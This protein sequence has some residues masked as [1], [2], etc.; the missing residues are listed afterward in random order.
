MPSGI[1]KFYKP[2]K[3]Y[4]FITSRNGADVFVHTSEME[5]AGLFTIKDGDE[6]SFEIKR[7]A[8]AGKPEAVN[9]KLI[10]AGPVGRPRSEQAKQ[11]EHVWR[12]EK[13][14]PGSRSE[15]REAAE[16]LIWA[17]GSKA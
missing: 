16:H 15:P 12:P 6:V 9:L 1:V 13:R 2:L 14:E 8:R 17:K 7:D 3:G 11:G 10:K 4:G 5:R